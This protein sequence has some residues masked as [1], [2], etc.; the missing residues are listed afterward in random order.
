MPISFF[1]KDA[2][3]LYIVCEAESS[4]AGDCICK[5]L[6]QDVRKLLGQQGNGSVSMTRPLGKD[7]G[8]WV[9]LKSLTD[10]VNAL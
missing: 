6:F 1:D 3:G 10:F 5:C 2:L 7:Q 9:R 8:R 4:I